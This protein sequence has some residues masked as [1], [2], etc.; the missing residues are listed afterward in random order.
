MAGMATGGGRVRLPVLMV[1]ALMGG[2]LAAIPAEVSHADLARP[3]IVV[4]MTD[5][6]DVP[7]FNTAIATGSPIGMTNYNALFGTETTAFT[8]SFVSFS[9]CCPSRSSFLTGQY[10]HNHGVKGNGGGGIGGCEDFVDTST[11]A[12]W[13]SDDTGANYYTGLVG[14]YLNDYG[15]LVGSSARCGD[16]NKPPGWDEWDALDY[17]PNRDAAME[18]G[19]TYTDTENGLTP[20]TAGFDYAHDYQTHA[21]GDRAVRFIQRAPNDRP[22]FL[23]LAPSAPHLDGHFDTYPPGGYTRC[24]DNWEHVDNQGHELGKSASIGSP[25]AFRTLAD[26]LS[27]PQTGS[28]NEADVSD[29]PQYIHDATNPLLKDDPSDPEYPV[30]DVAC[31]QKVW[32]DRLES[33]K[34]VDLMIG[35]VRDALIQKHEVDGSIALDNTVVIFTSDNGYFNGQHRLHEK[36]FPYEEGIRVPLVV[37]YKDTPQQSQDDHFVL[38]N[39][40]APTVLSLA[41]GCPPDLPLTDRCFKP[42][43]QSFVGF[44][45]PAI[46]DPNPWRKRFLLEHWFDSHEPYPS[47]PDFIG[48]RTI[49]GYPDTTTTNAVLLAYDD[50]PPNGTYDEFEYYDLD[51]QPAQLTNTY[52]T[53]GVN[54]TQLQTF[55]TLLKACGGGPSSPTA[56]QTYENENVP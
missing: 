40:L 48:V 1:L 12:T 17:G 5:D 10:A 7:S 36:V 46:P 2:I 35:A 11:L 31:T 32:Q 24:G 18:L 23:Y 26:G 30:T 52:A 42:D 25:P 55:V 47:V 28:F 8:N 54:Y 4:I 43:G 27:I 3:N 37:R 39:D 20:A 45:D 22:F 38:N 16:H 33:L 34:S 15:T 53:S 51:T 19:Y 13:L 6:L 29:K 21:L 44:L 56:C 50:A 49:P 14:K 41:G 9:L